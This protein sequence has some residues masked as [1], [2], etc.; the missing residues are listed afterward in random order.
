MKTMIRLFIL[1]TM[2]TMTGHAFAANSLTVT[3][4][5][6]TTTITVG[7][8]LSSEFTE[9]LID[10]IKQSPLVEETIN[11]WVAPGSH[12]KGDGFSLNLESFTGSSQALLM[13]ELK[14]SEIKQVTTHH[15][16]LRVVSE[17]G[18]FKN[19]HEAL[20]ASP[21][22]HAIT[23]DRPNRLIT[24]QKGEVAVL[25]G[26]VFNRS[27]GQISCTRGFRNFVQSICD[28]NLQ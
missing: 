8:D 19:F 11:P 14:N 10:V 16:F 23:H 3:T 20:E 9:K 25:E 5:S 17:V 21:S 6:Q 26:E 15:R 2:F 22:Q 4:T 27:L 24:R 28:L 12:F 7:L 18:A 1:F 13:F